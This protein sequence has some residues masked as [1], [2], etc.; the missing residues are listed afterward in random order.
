MQLIKD[1]IALFMAILA[2]AG[3]CISIGALMGLTF[4]VAKTV[5]TLLGA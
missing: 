1:I 3:I 2:I 5:A 4:Y